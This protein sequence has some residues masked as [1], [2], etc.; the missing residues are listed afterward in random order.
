M[1]NEQEPAGTGDAADEGAA[2]PAGD[3]GSA[4]QD[5]QRQF[6]DAIGKLSGPGEQL[7]ALGAGLLIFVD[8]FADLIFDEYSIEYMQLIPAW[9]VVAAVVLHRFRN[10]PL[11]V[12][13][14]LLLAVL[15]LI[16]GLAGVREFL[17]GIENSIFD[18]DSATI[19]YAL[20][21]W[22]G[23]ILM[24]VGAIQLWPTA[25]NG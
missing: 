10:A 11:P 16:A 1:T 13:Y 23:S 8:V 24:L 2:T 6:N 12:A 18:A 17:W 25:K 5:I 21:S 4:G 14:P 7:V 15:G 19:I 20:I 22:A 9:F 3:G